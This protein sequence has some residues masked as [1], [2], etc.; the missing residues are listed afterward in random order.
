[1]LEEEL[2]ELRARAARD[3]AATE[4]WVPLLAAHLRAGQ[5]ARGAG[6][7]ARCLARA[8]DD[9]GSGAAYLEALRRGGYS[10]GDPRFL[11]GPPDRARTCPTLAWEARGR[12]LAVRAGPGLVRILEGETGAEVGRVVFAGRLRMLRVLPA[13]PALLLA[14]LPGEG[15]EIVREVRTLPGGEL[16]DRVRHAWGPGP[17]AGGD[18]GRPLGFTPGDASLLVAQ[19]EELVVFG[20]PGTE[21]AR[22]YLGGVALRVGPVGVAG[23]LLVSTR[24][25]EGANGEFRTLVVDV[26]KRRARRVHQG[27]VPVAW[28]ADPAGRAMAGI[29]WAP[30]YG[31]R[32]TRRN[33]IDGALEVRELPGGQVRFEAEVQR[34]ARDGGTWTGWAEGGQVVVV[35]STTRLG[36]F[37]A[38]SGAR[39]WDD[40]FPRPEP[41][42]FASAAGGSSF[43]L[44]RGREL[45]VLDVRT[46]RPVVGRE[47]WRGEVRVLR[48]SRDGRR[49][50]RLVDGDSAIH[51]WERGAVVTNFDGERVVVAEDLAGWLRWGRRWG[52]THVRAGDAGPGRELTCIEGGELVPSVV[53]DHAG[54][55]ILVL[56]NAY[57][58][59]DGPPHAVRVADLESDRVRRDLAGRAEVRAFGVHHRSGHLYVLFGD[60][61]LLVE[62]P[63]GG[64]GV[65][66]ALPPELAGEGAVVREQVEGSRVVVTRAG[67]CWEVEVASGAARDLPGLEEDPRALALHPAGDRLAVATGEGPVQIL[68]VPGGATLGEI[69]LPGGPVST[70]AYSPVGDFLLVPEGSHVRLHPS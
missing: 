43:A 18:A 64:A 2:A 10:I 57:P 53:L 11:A 35:G 29:S 61:E 60:G 14:Y 39:L 45:R 31:P 22:I 66:H 19:G 25:P 32:L 36:A 56:E 4:N 38:T 70:L 21:V 27:P 59:P 47:G 15:P 42:D 28:E 13:G 23:T 12:F 20:V 48:F 7:L 3:P 44:A 16:V 1:M 62:P 49:L 52:L 8:G 69:E 17:E 41:V 68:A 54:G 40:G 46:G 51:D 65:R 26:A 5:G 34:A 9:A 58:D 6:A 55:R 63:G 50:L 67:S 37:D 30:W 24:P 33:R